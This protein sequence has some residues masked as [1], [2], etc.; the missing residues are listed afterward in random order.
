MIVPTSAAVKLPPSSTVVLAAVIV[1]VLVQFVA[2]LADVVLAAP[3]CSVVT[4]PVPLMLIVPAFV[5]AP[6]IV[7]VEPFAPAIVPVLEF[8]NVVVGS[9]FKVEVALAVRVP[10]LVNVA[11]VMSRMWPPPLGVPVHQRPGRQRDQRERGGSGRGEQADLQRGG[12]EQ[13]DCRQRQR[14]LGDGRAH[15]ADCL[16]APQQQE[17]AMPPQASGGHAPTLP[18]RRVGCPTSI[19]GAG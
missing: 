7:T 4:P 17:V 5:T 8:V 15:L 16:P 9:T 10:L 6:V 18:G 19:S 3:N 1:P 2:V 12:T 11:G 13:D 14:E